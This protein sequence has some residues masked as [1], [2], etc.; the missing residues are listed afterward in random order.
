MLGIGAVLLLS[1]GP[2]L[3]ENEQPSQQA[4]AIRGAAVGGTQLEAALWEE[5]GIAKMVSWLW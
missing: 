4:W 5:D 2:C 3:S 1:G